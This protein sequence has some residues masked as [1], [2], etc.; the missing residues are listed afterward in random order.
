VAVIGFDDTHV[1]QQLE[2]NLTSVH[3]D[4]DVL[5]EAALDLVVTRLDN[6]D[7]KGRVSVI[8]PTLTIRGSG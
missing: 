1:A 3:Q 2:F 7:R 6:P 8:A 4:P 5:A